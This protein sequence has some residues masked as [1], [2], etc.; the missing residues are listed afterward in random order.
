M[1]P[2][3]AKS[4]GREL[5]KAVAAKIIEVFDLQEGDAVSR[6]MGSGG[7]DIMMS[8]AARKAFPITIECK[9]TTSVP[10]QP[11]LDQAAHNCYPNTHPAVVWK[12]RGVGP[13]KSRVMM[14]LNVFLD[15]IKKLKE[16]K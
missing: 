5:Q 13:D 16:G 4:K 3:S 11:A 2:S 15:L 1:R 12:P 14:E 7:T 10:G 9:S 8:P 6:P